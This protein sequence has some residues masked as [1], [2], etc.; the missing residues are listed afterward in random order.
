MHNMKQHEGRALSLSL[1]LFF[2]GK[3]AGEPAQESGGRQ[4]SC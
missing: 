2:I 3:L 1:A 4:I